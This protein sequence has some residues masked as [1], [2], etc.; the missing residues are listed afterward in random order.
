MEKEE[1]VSKLKETVEELIGKMGFEAEISAGISEDGGRTAY[2]CDIRTDESNFLIGQHGMNL[3]SMQHI[4]R[5]LFRRKFNE[6]ADFVID[7]NSY[8]KEK[9]ETIAKMAK[10]LAEEAILGNHAIVM[11]PMSPYERR[12]VHLELSSDERI[13]TES[14]GEGEDRRIVIKPVGLD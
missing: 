12:V 1:I 6:N 7:I 2:V 5:V 4:A 8:R 9:N 13:S 14:V 11:R 3:Q 10:G